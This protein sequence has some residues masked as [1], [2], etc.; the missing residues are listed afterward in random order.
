[1][2]RRCRSVGRT[3]GD[4]NQ[5]KKYSLRLDAV[6][7]RPAPLPAR[8][9]GVSAPSLFHLAWA[10]VLAATSGERDDVVFGTVLVGRL[11]GGDGATARWGCLSIPCRCV[12]ISIMRHQAQSD[13][14]WPDH[15]IAWA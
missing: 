7:S 9:L 4:G 13:G 5:I 11:Q 8:F 15:A 12:W 6:E 1:M 10:T 3:R 2:S 14:P